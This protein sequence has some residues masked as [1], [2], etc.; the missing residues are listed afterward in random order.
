MYVFPPKSSWKPDFSSFFR[1]ND[2]PLEHDQPMDEPNEPLECALTLGKQPNGKWQNKQP[3]VD[4]KKKIE[5][6]IEK[7]KTK[8]GYGK[9]NERKQRKGIKD[10]KFCLLGTN[11]NGLLGKQ[12]SLKSAI[13]SFKPS[14]ITIQESKLTRK[15]LIKLKGYQLFEKL[16][17]GGQG[18]GLL[19]AVDA[20]LLLFLVSTGT[21]EET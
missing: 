10:I 15:G 13:N 16:R 18:G 19:T 4:N 3:A 9:K 17:P 1:T 20:D 12:E 11:S 6:K 2:A 7:P 14:V 5:K 8:R 21:E